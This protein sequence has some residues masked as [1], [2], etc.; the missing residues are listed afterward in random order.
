M[1]SFDTMLAEYDRI[2]K[3]NTNRVLHA[4]GIP[5]VILSVIGL[6]G[7]INI[8][9]TGIQVPEKYTWIFTLSPLLITYVCAWTFKLSKRAALAMAVLACVLWM[10]A[11]A[12]RYALGDGTSALSFGA[13]FVGGWAILFTG[14]AFEGESPEFV[15]RPENL[16]L[17]PISVLNDFF[18]IARVAR[19][20]GES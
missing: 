4:F 13:F 11:L 12:L 1:A 8:G 17:G 9:I 5:S 10:I 3:S 15:Q 6:T 18:P 19:A 14:H 16:I 2:H 20:G 7:F